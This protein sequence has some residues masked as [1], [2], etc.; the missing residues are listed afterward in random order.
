M[1][2]V[3]F[4]WATLFLALVA[5]LSAATI[6]PAQSSDES[7][8][9]TP[10]PMATDWSHRH[11]VFSG[12]DA[13]AHSSSAK[14]LQLQ[15]DRRFQQQVARRGASARSIVPA[16]ASVASRR[17]SRPIP[18]DP[19]AS[20]TESSLSRDWTS[21]LTSFGTV[22]NEQYPAKFEF[23]INAPVSAT[24]CTSDFVVYNN[25]NA[26]GTHTGFIEYATDSGIF[27]GV[28]PV[29]SSI[30]ITPPATGVPVVF[31]AIDNA[32]PV[33]SQTF[34][35]GTDTASAAANL[36]A[37]INSYAAST[38]GAAG[39]FPYAAGTFFGNVVYVNAVATTGVDSG[40]GGNNTTAAP[41]DCYPFFGC[42][43]NFT[44]FSGNFFGGAGGTTASV[45]NLIGL[46]NLY[47]GNP[48]GICPGTA[49]TV[50]FA[51]GVSTAQGET[52]TSAGLS[53]D[54]KQ[55]AIVESTPS[56]QTGQTGCTIGSVLHLVKW[57][58]GTGT[59]NNPVVPQYETAQAYRGCTAPCMTSITL[60]ASPDTNSAPFIDYTNDAIYVGDDSGKIREITGVFLGTPTLG[61]QTTVDMGFAL[62][63]PVYDSVSGNIFVADANGELSAVAQSSG[64]L[65]PQAFT[66]GTHGYP[67]PDPPIVDSTAETVTVFV[68]NNGGGSAQVIQY[69]VGDLAAPASVVVGP[70]GVQ[71]HDG[72]FD[73]TYYSGNYADGF[74]YFCGK[75]PGGSNDNPAIERIPFNSSGI[76]E[77]ASFDSGNVLPV[78]AVQSAECS[79]MTEVYNGGVD[80]MFFSVQTGGNQP[81]CSILGGTGGANSNPSEGCVMSIIVTDGSTTAPTPPFPAAINSSLGEPGGSS[82]IILD[83]VSPAAQ[84]SS[85]YFSPLAFANSKKAPNGNCGMGV[86]CAVKATQA[87]LD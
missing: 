46:M 15:A 77:G 87:G 47:S 2:I 66:S 68:S 51:Y 10:L 27:W 86:G 37:A 78:S 5:L 67:I 12:A 22:G 49:P 39:S 30:S 72:D 31:T 56:C 41:D 40:A 61:W 55:I 65:G 83:N 60:S 58:N 21:S 8:N 79:P 17:V 59:L 50:K 11:L 80:Y 63:G 48:A 23:D 6:L 82:G 3:R 16:A 24:N 26:S 33:T 57:S 62:T 45:A 70:A 81:N 64:T 9:H 18:S 25:N 13:R 29:G 43:T 54:G 35:Q 71:M 73:N 36:A 84:A 52:T 44:F 7:V 20:A 19:A 53:E 38:G 1:T 4:S 69:P 14:D 85:I 34:Q 28:P 32:T 75:N 42:N 74:L 76:L